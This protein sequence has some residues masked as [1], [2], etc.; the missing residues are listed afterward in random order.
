MAEAKNSTDNIT[1]ENMPHLESI[2]RVKRIPLIH[3]AIEKTESTYS[4]LKDSNQL[5]N[6]ALSNAEAGL[7]YATATA[8]PLTAPLAKKFEEQI[9]AVDQKL[10]EGLNIVEQKVPIMKQ[11]PQQIY[12]AA[13]AVMNSSLQP[14]IDKLHAAKESATQQ[15][16]TLKDISIVKANELLNTEYGNMAVQGVDN[17]SILINGLLDR[18]FPPVEGEENM[19]VP[20][21][22]DENKVLHAVQTIGQLSAKT[23]N[24]VYHSIVA[25]LKTVKKEDVSSYM[26]SVISILHLTHFLSLNEKQTDNKETQNV[27][28][29]K[30]EKN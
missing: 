6:W 3:S 9:T 25:Q 7:H 19:P 24:R 15:A 1:S 10:C 20:V 8:A 18:Y 29:E 21:S 12:D 16:S 17:T 4:Y 26:S 22:A 30:K 14:T 11:P 23:A 27:A 28:D 5:I 2:E 13:K